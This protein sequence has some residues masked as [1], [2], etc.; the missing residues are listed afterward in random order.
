MTLRRHVDHIHKRYP[1]ETTTQD[2]WAMPD[3]LSSHVE[4][5]VRE[6]PLEPPIIPPSIP[7]PPLVHSSPERRYPRRIRAPIDRFSPTQYS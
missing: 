3:G 6:I 2:D 7:P 5:T 1:T 4:V